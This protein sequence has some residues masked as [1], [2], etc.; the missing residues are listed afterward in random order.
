MVEL[1]ATFSDR[2]YE[3]ISKYARE[4]GL[5][6][7]E[8]LRRVMIERLE[9]E[10]DIHEADAAYAEWLKNPVTISHEELKRELGL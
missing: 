1:T 6:E 5:S 3:A 7:S 10:D 4:K 9:D 8:Y 2:A